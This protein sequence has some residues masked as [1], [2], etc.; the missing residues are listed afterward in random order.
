MAK[1]PTPR[2]TKIQPLHRAAFAQLRNY[3]PGRLQMASE[4]S[5]IRDRKDASVDLGPYA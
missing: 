4:T 5:L 1:S 2:S 3:V